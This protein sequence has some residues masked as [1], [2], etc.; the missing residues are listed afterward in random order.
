MIFHAS[1]SLGRTRQKDLAGL[2]KLVTMLYSLSLS[3]SLIL[4]SSV[5]SYILFCN[6]HRLWAAAVVIF[7]VRSPRWRHG[8][9]CI[10]PVPPTVPR[11]LAGVS[12]ASVAEGE[13][14]CER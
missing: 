9:V 6:V 7:V 5:D 12:P 4:L 10:R 3:L 11:C 14:R 8:W 13:N 2:C 1:V